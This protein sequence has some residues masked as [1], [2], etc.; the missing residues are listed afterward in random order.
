MPQRALGPTVKSLEGTIL[1]KVLGAAEGLY[2]NEQERLRKSIKHRRIEEEIKKAGIK[3]F[4]LE[5]VGGM[6]PAMGVTKY[7]M[8]G[9][10]VDKLG[11]EIGTATYKSM[12]SKLGLDAVGSEFAKRYPRLAAH[13]TPEAIEAGEKMH[14]GDVQ[15]RTFWGRAFGKGNEQ[16]VPVGISG[17]AI[18][19]RKTM[20]HEATHVAQKLGMGKKTS[21]VYDAAEELVSYERNPME[22]SA[23][24][25]ALRYGL[26]SGRDI[27]PYN[28]KKGLEHVV[29]TAE[30]GTA[31]RLRL[32]RALR[33]S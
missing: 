29:E 31:K 6:S 20:A 26:P 22:L 25:T 13:I 1:E 7:V 5:D 28:T 23:R 2:G 3:P 4:S 10:G 8:P 16:T 32:A 21:N 11:R 24:R 9:G 14:G 15:G 33:G 17:A 12:M 18:N 27:L 30:P 19:P